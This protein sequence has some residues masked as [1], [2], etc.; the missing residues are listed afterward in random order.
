MVNGLSSKR[1]KRYEQIMRSFI[2]R[3]YII[4]PFDMWFNHWQLWI[5]MNVCF[6]IFG[7]R[8]KN[9]FAFIDSNSFKLRLC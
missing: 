5:H 4:Y 3:S 1:L 9:S 6:W 8:E 7:L 2:I